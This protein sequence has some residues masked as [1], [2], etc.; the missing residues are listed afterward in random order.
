MANQSNWARA[1]C[2]ICKRVLTAQQQSAFVTFVISFKTA[3]VPQY[4]FWSLAWLW[5]TLLHSLP[6]LPD[7]RFQT[8]LHNSTKGPSNEHTICKKDRLL[9]PK[10]CDKYLCCRSYPRLCCYLPAHSSCHTF[11]E[12]RFVP[13]LI[14]FS[15]ATEMFCS[16]KIPFLCS[17]QYIRSG[18]NKSPL[19]RS[20]FVCHH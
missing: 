5:F 2:A 14:I 10:M 16:N 20:V 12:L 4:F 19:M 7:S 18:C 1:N 8:S 13:S 15:F 17:C 6:L 11:D 9:P 3:F